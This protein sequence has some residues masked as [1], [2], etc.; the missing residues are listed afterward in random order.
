MKSFNEDP[1]ER[2]ARVM[3]FLRQRAMDR[4]A[5]AG[6]R[7]ALTDA[8][9]SRAWPLLAQ[10]EGIGDVAIETV[11]GLYATWPQEDDKGNLGAWFRHIGEGGSALEGRFKRLL[12]CTTRDE[13]CAHLRPLANLAKSRNAPLNHEELLRDLFYWSDEVRVR[14]ARSFWGGD[15]A[16]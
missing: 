11:A 4:G 8:R 16:G 13:L 14:W 15:A 6:L 12:S 9:R 7:C 1:R 10:V 5:M 3:T 2:A